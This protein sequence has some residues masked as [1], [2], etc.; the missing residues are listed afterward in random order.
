MLSHHFGGS[1]NKVM[2]TFSIPARLSYWIRHEIFTLM[3]L[4]VHLFWD[5]TLGRRQLHT[6]RHSFM[7]RQNWVFVHDVISLV[8]FG[9]RYKLWGAFVLP[10]MGSAGWPKVRLWVTTVDRTCVVAA[11]SA[12]R[13]SSYNSISEDD[14]ATGDPTA[15]SKVLL[16]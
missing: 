7:F 14:T 10:W 13:V 11:M 4:A 8:K 15:Q 3:L 12:F 6:Q 5:D 16:E 9:E 1:K 2:Y